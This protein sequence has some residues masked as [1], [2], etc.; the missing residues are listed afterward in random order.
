MVRALRGT[1]IAV[2]CAGELHS[3]VLSRDGSVYCFGDSTLGQTAVTDGHPLLEPTRLPTRSPVSECAVGDH[4]T[5]VRPCTPA[6]AATHVC[7]ART[8]DAPKRGCTA[9]EWVGHRAGARPSGA[10]GARLVLDAP[11]IRLCAHPGTHAA[12]SLCRAGAR[13]VARCASVRAS[14]WRSARTLRA[15]WVW[16]RRAISSLSRRECDGLASVAVTSLSVCAPVVT[17]AWR[18]V[19]CAVM[20]ACTRYNRPT[21]HRMRA[22]CAPQR[23]KG[24]A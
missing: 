19:S 20:A 15:S 13:R 11:P 3:C 14:S 5:M 23:A 10:F 24:D 18:L 8:G 9:H 4:H 1:P 2:A 17:D 22:A 7:P 12:L 21:S 16:A 6:H